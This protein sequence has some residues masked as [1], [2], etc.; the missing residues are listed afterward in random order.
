[1]YIYK[2][3]EFSPYCLYTVGYYE[4]G[5]NVWMPESDHNT[6]EEAAQRVHYLNGS[7]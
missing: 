7:N 4:L 3:T 5:T 1:M 2:R 6:S